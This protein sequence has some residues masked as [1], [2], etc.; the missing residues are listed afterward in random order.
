MQD[1]DPKHTSKK[2]RQ[3]LGFHSLIIPPWP[4]NS[5]D[6]NPVK[7]LWNH[8]KKDSLIIPNRQMGP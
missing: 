2:A 1:N 3:F 7:H 4:A 6:L 8:T 5:P